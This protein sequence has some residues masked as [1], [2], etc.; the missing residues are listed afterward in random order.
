ME[1]TFEKVKEIYAGDVLDIYYYD[2]EMTNLAATIL[3]PS[4]IYVTNIN[5]ISNF[6]MFSTL[7]VVG[8]QVILENNTWCES[9]DLSK[10]KVYYV[11]YDSL[12]TDEKNL[13]IAIAFYTFKGER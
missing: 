10:D 2:K 6:D 7:S 13:P 3:R 4:S 8:Q 9:S 1:K 11:R 12:Y 5:Y